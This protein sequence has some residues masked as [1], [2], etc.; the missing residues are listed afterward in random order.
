MKC[1]FFLY[2]VQNTLVLLKNHHNHLELLKK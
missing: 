1:I 2:F